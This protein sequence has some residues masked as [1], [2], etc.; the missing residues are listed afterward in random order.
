MPT[1]STLFY[2]YLFV[3]IIGISFSLFGQL[4]GGGHDLDHSDVHHA[5]GAHHGSIA[6]AI[7]SFR[8]FLVFMV[9]FGASGLL[10][11]QA[12]L[13]AWPSIGCAFIGGLIL[14]GLIYL[15]F[16]AVGRQQGNTLSNPNALVGKRARVS[17]AIPPNG[18]GE[19]QTTNEFGSSVS[20]PARSKG[21]VEAGRSVN[22]EGVDGGVATVSVA[23]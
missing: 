12:G 18:F 21:A 17:I 13:T 20:L 10:A 16:E 22:V 2:V 14:A 4:L 11:I 8:N 3:A 19:I 7:F 9:G 23:A 1:L 5:D 6:S 15:F